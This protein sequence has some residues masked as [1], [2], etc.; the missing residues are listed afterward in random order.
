MR[1]WFFPCGCGWTPEP[2]LIPIEGYKIGQNISHISIL[3]LYFW[4]KVLFLTKKSDIMK[5]LRIFIFFSNHHFL[6]LP[7]WPLIFFRHRQKLMSQTKV[8][9]DF[10]LNSS[11][12]LVS[13]RYLKWNWRRFFRRDQTSVQN[14]TH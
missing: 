10:V 2:L 13:C 5:W 7:L 4:P 14:F 3:I 8:N 6:V 12:V 11:N 1:F 9:A